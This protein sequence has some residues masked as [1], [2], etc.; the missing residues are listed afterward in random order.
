MLFE[1]RK[2]QLLQT[3]SQVENLAYLT[4]F[5]VIYCLQQR[6]FFLLFF[7]G[8]FCM[9]FFFLSSFC[10]SLCVCVFAIT[11]LKTKGIYSYT[12][13]NMWAGKIEKHFF[14]WPISR[15]KTTFFFTLPAFSQ[16]YNYPCAKKTEC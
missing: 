3:N 11:F 7:F 16:N 6:Q 14:S 5:L 10:F 12:H 13:S 9:S 4:R 15:N 2:N 1:E 8:F